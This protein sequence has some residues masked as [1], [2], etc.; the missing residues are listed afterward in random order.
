MSSTIDWSKAPEGAM[1]A[2]AKTDAVDW[3]YCDTS[4][5]YKWD[6]S[7]S[8]WLKLSDREVIL[9]R[10]SLAYIQQRPIEPQEPT[11]WNGEGLPPVGTVCELNWGGGVWKRCTVFAHRPNANGGIDALADIEGDWTFSS[12]PSMFRPIKTAKQIA[13][14]ERSAAVDEM[15]KTFYQGNTV[16]GGADGFNALYNAGYRKVEQP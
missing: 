3:Y 5:I 15:M 12:R 9:L 7:L 1:Q 2:H 4:G 8:S 13:A 11:K 16:V 6:E 14:E 10:S